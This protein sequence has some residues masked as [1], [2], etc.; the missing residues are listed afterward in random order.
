MDETRSIDGFS[1]IFTNAICSVQAALITSTKAVSAWCLA[2]AVSIESLN[3][4]W[5]WKGC[6]VVEILVYRQKI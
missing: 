2:T 1:Q 4:H 5:L 3:A 6:L